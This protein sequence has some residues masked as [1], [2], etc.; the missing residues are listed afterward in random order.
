MVKGYYSVFVI[1]SLVFS[2]FLF[3]SCASLINS[4][5]MNVYVSTN[6]DSA[7]I[8]IDTSQKY[9]NLPASIN[10]KRSKS[11]IN[12]IYTSDS[13]SFPIVLTSN[14]SSAF[15]FG[16]LLPFGIPGYLIDV[17]N[18]R[19]YSY[20]REVTIVNNGIE[21]EVFYNDFTTPE[22][23]SFNLRFSIPFFNILTINTGFG[24]SINTGFWGFITGAE[25]YFTNHMCVQSNLGI[26]ADFQ[27]PFP[28]PID[29]DSQLKHANALFG[30]IQ[31]G[32]DLDFIHL[33][34]GLHFNETR[35][36]ND[37][38]PMQVIKHFQNNFGFS[39]DN[40]VKL[41]DYLSVTIKYMPSFYSFQK[42]NYRKESSGILSL[43]FSI[44]I[45][46]N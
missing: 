17:T 40:Y 23:G 24:E 19:K 37:G 36:T 7:T 32:F 5:T 28:S 13:I 27:S 9:Y 14:I 46:T 8:R 30:D 21:H 45:K 29:Y 6:D 11:D 42:N 34:F 39:M 3:N 20:P 25:Y 15:L 2:S 35:Y 22:K 44:L 1:I 31:L 4:K 41:N 18:P 12:L 26:I 16:N 10:I 43:G 33:G 38:N